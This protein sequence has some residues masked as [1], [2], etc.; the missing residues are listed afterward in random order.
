MLCRRLRGCRYPTTEREEAKGREA[1]SKGPKGRAAKGRAAKGRAAMG[2]VAKAEAAKVVAD[3]SRV[4]V[5]TVVRE[6]PRRNSMS[7]GMAVFARDAVGKGAVVGG[8]AVFD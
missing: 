7:L 8:A 3:H 6:V 4:S 1:G 2:R 5:G